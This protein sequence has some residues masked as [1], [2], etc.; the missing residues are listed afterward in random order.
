MD[1]KAQD[2]HS[3]STPLCQ[4]HS[5]GNRK[6]QEPQVAGNGNCID[7]SVGHTEIDADI[8]G[9]KPYHVDE[10][11]RQKAEH[12]RKDNGKR[13]LIHH[14]GSVLEAHPSLDGMDE[15][16]YHFDVY[17]LNAVG[18]PGGRCADSGI[19]FPFERIAGRAS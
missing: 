3:L 8:V 19:C 1:R 10:P 13:I 18:I 5:H 17:L 16:V 2:N 14:I 12:H 6:K 7:Q 4:S 15:N 9:D 11:H